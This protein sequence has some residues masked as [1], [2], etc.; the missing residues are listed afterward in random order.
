MDEQALKHQKMIE[1]L[2]FEA[3]NIQRQISSPK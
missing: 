2:D 1:I 3:Q